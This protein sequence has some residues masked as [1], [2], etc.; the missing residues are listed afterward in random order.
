MSLPAVDWTFEPLAWAV[1]WSRMKG[2]EHDRDRAEQAM[3][4]APGV[5][6]AMAAGWLGCCLGPQQAGRPGWCPGAAYSAKV[7]ISLKELAGL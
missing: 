5:A 7:V 6:E 3:A 1:D 4:P 2:S